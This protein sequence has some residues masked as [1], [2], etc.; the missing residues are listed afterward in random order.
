VN[1]IMKESLIM[2]AM[3]AADSQGCHL[4]RVRYQRLELD[5]EEGL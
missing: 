2:C 4:N 1:A 5:V 3:Y